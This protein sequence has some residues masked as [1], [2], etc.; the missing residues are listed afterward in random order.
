MEAEDEFKGVLAM[1]PDFPA[2]QLE[3]AE[4]YVRKGSPDL[5]LMIA[6]HMQRLHPKGAAGFQLEG[7]ILMAKRQPAQALA[8]YQ[9]AFGMR[10][11]T[12]LAIKIDNAL[13]QAG[14]KDEATRRLDAWLAQHGDDLRAQAY[15]A[16]TWL[17]ERRFQPAA[18]QL[19]AVLKRQPD[20]PVALNNLALAYQGL[21]DAR[22]QATAEAA[23][24]AA[25]DQ[26]DV[27]D[28]LAWIVAEKGDLARA[29]GL[30][31]KAH[32]LSPKA[33]DIRYHMAAVLYRSGDKD[34]ARRELEALAAGDMRFAQADEV[35]ALLAEVRRGG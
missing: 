13:R 31:K 32:A 25:G 35:R 15:R 7:D 23:L 30:L 17:A 1:Q 29:L 16:Q 24:R 27:I 8:P 2:A 5:A 26:P 34:Q 18:S 9:T 6:E 4:I 19:E 11:V 22:A 21:G 33:R 28:T 20:N 12:E 3:L 14:R 10:P